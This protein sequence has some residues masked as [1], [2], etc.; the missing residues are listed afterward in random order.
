MPPVTLTIGTVKGLFLATSDDSRSRWSIEGPLMKGWDIKDVAIDRRGPEPR[1]LAAVNSY[2]YGATVLASSDLGRTW[3]S[4]G[5]PPRFA[6]DAQRKVNAIWKVTPAHAVHP[7]VLYAGVDE[8]G[9][10]RS[11]DN[12]ASWQEVTSLNDHPTRS[13]WCPGA[14]GLCLHTIIQSPSDPA[15]LWIG[16]SAVGVF[17]TDDAG[18]TW[19]ICNEGIRKMIDS[20][21]HAGIGFCPHGLCLHPE[22]SDILYR[23]D[24]AG[25]YRSLDAADSWEH[26]AGD[27]PTEFGFPIVADRATGAVFIVP[28]EKDEYRFTL[29]GKLRVYRSAKGDAQWEPLT[30]GLP[31]ENAWETILRNAMDGDGL[32]R[33][34]I[35][36]G[37]TSG[38]VYASADA[39]ESWSCLPA[40][41]PRVQS[42][43]AFAHL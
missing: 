37:T 2:V 34:G 1:L 28:L 41:F 31:Q 35:Y 20:Q 23:Q 22:N 10:F 25:L 11:G 15:R 5:E 8:G 26:I 6:P 17:R 24:H 36:F 29:D 19:K 4:A 16:I 12:G 30:N 3:E 7:G 21:D 14:G 43:T 42:V 38:R 13:G 32:D 33:G 39:G 9:L 27:I 18:E 40:I